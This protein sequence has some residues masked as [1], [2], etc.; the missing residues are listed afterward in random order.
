MPDM[1]KNL[2]TALD[3]FN[4]IKGDESRK[5]DWGYGKGTGTGVGSGNGTG[6]TRGSK[7]TGTGGGGNAEGEFVSDKG[8]I[9]TGKE[10]PGGG[11]CAKPPCGTS[12]KEVKVAVGEAEGDIEGLTAEEIN[13]VVKARAGVFRACYQKELNRSPGLGGKVVMHFVIG[14]DGTV[15]S[16]KTAGGTTMHNEAVEECINRQIMGL[17][18]PAKGG[19]SNVN[20]PFVFQPGG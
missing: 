9:D 14:G 11:T 10:R 17:H 2:V 18:F 8:K 5:G 15:K 3:K 4:G 13:R 1:D 6:T 16:A 19:I 7:G 12:A 20:Y